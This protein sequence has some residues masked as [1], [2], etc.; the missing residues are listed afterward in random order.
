MTAVDP[1]IASLICIIRDQRVILDMDLAVLYGV[2]TRQFNQAFKRNRDRFP[3]EFAFH[4]SANEF[5][6]LNWSQTVTS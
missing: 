6:A 3:R 5:A 2:R 4:L 1:K